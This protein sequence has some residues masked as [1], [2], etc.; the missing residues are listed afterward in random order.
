LWL[1]RPVIASWIVTSACQLWFL[2]NKERQSDFKQP[3]DKTIEQCLYSDWANRGDICS[4]LHRNRLTLQPHPSSHVL[5]TKS[6]CQGIKQPGRKLTTH[7]H[8]VPRLKMCTAIPPP[9]QYS[10][11]VCTDTVL[12]F[13]LVRLDVSTQHALPVSSVSQQ[14]TACCS[15]VAR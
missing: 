11:R 8:R 1:C 13:Y 3:T 5:G 4:L 6:C 7:C 14:I 9:T 10:C 15:S 2:F 12:P